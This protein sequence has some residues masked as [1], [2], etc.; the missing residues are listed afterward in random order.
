M[1]ISH[2]LLLIC[3]WAGEGVRADLDEGSAFV[4]IPT[5]LAQAVCD[6]HLMH[7]G[8]SED[9]Y[10]YELPRKRT[11]GKVPAVLIGSACLV[12][13]HPP[14]HAATAGRRG[15]RCAAAL[16]SAPGGSVAQALF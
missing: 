11:V 16:L 9:T 5:D 7:T 6:L 2:W 10:S 12:A 4:S 8:K 1:T 13:L 3:A 14:T 15:Q